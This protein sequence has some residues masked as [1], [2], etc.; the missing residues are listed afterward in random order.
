M[1]HR[2]AWCL[3]CGFVYHLWPIH[4]TIPVGPHLPLCTTPHP[5]VP[6]LFGPHYI[7]VTHHRFLCPSTLA[8]TCLL[9]APPC[10]SPGQPGLRLAPLATTHSPQPPKAQGS[11]LCWPPGI[12]LGLRFHSL[13]FQYLHLTSPPHLI[14]ASFST[15]SRISIRGGPNPLLVGA[16]Y[17]S[18]K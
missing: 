18:G 10:P 14:P 7:H 15:T 13:P 12:P 17:M 2:P 16:P 8:P 4:R 11:L 1:L 3:R 5:T 9:L 6:V